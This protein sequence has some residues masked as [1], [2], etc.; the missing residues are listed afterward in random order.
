MSWETTVHALADHLDARCMEGEAYTATLAAESSDFV[1]FNHGRVRQPGSVTQATVALRWLIGRRHATHQVTLNGEADHDRHRLDEAIEALRAWVPELPE[2]PHLAVSEE[3]VVRT[4]TAD[5][6]P[7]EPEAV[8]DAVIAA[9]ASSGGQPAA[10]LVGIYAGGTLHRGLISRYGHRL[11]ETSCS[12]QLDAS[13]VHT[14]DKAVKTTYA[15]TTWDPDAL[16]RHLATARSRLKPLSRPSKT[17][18]PGA[19]RAYLAPAAV[20]ELFGLLSWEDFSV[21]AQRDGSSA[22]SRLVRGEVRLDPRVQVYEDTAHGTAPAF[23]EDGFLRPDRVDLIRD[24]RHAG[25]LVSPRSAIELGLSTNGASAGEQP[26]SLA[27]APGALPT[28]RVLAELGT[29]VWV[30]NLWYT[31]HSDRNAGRITGMTRFACFWVE[32][33]ELVAPIDVMRFDASIHD[34]FGEGLV[35][36]TDEAAFLPSTSTY[37]H[38]STDSQR[39]PGALVEGLTFTL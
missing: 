3:G 24:G 29:G 33:G 30:S 13:F 32:D 26:A 7:P 14:A 23:Q 10:D 19:Y 2:D 38:R 16:A 25:A 1:R 31:N 9:A 21:Q 22:L 8:I 12:H 6:A 27:M 39:L 37:G 36:L 11:A 18:S 20:A 17:L 35:A 28:Q 5:A 15:A 4:V 34:L